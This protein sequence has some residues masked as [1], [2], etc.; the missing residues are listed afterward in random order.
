[1]WHAAATYTD[2][3][4]YI[5]INK[6]HIIYTSILNTQVYQHTQTGINLVEIKLFPD[7]SEKFQ[8]FLVRFKVFSLNKFVRSATLTLCYGSEESHKLKISIKM[9]P[10]VI[11]TQTNTALYKQI[12]RAHDKQI[13]RA[14]ILITANKLYLC[15][16]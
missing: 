16:W 8:F 2:N 11:W 9:I 3:N 5:Y 1:M 15:L 10:V 14:L 6:W 13:N 12:N 7:I 4:I